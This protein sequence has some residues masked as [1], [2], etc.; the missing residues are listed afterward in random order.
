MKRI[1]LVTPSLGSGGAERVMSELAAY[2]ADTLH[3]HVTMIVLTKTEQFYKVPESVTVKEPS[4]DHK[5]YSRPVFSVKILQHLRKQLKSSKP[6]A[7]LTFGGRYNAFVLLASKGLG[8]RVFVS[9]RSKPGISYGGFQNFINPRQYKSATGIIAQ[10][11]A[12][13]A[14]TK[15]AIGHKNI[16]VIGNPI[17]QQPASTATRENIILSVGRFIRTKHQDLLIEYFSKIPNEGW[18]LVFLGDGAG[19]DA[20]RQKAA[21]LGIG[22]KVLFEG[23]VRNVNDYYNKSAI[24]ASTSSSEGFPNALGEAMATGMA[25]IS[26]DCVA[27]PADLIEHNHTGMLIAM[28]AHEAYADALKTMMANATLRENLGAAARKKIEEFSTP[29]IAQRFFD[30]MFPS[31]KN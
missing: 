11:R 16:A 9:D 22:D 1:T 4:F 6:D 21:A 19:L 29:V 17:R 24:Y 13:E 7:V 30:F 26:Y 10:T 20:C 2:F 18:K 8:L 3:H 27:G 31:A 12:A 28:N 23:A 5:K 15:K 25:C 14:F